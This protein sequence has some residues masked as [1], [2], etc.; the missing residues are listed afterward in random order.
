MGA[1]HSRPSSV[2]AEPPA[3]LSFL[4]NRCFRSVVEQVQVEVWEP[5]TTSTRMNQ[6][7]LQ[8][9]GAWRPLHWPPC[10]S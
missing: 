2:H 5:C 4:H 8:T 10:A 7:S 9:L 1:E 6:C 3:H